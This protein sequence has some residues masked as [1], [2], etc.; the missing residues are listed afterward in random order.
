MLCG[1]GKESM[2]VCV[3]SGIVCGHASPTRR[4]MGVVDASSVL[5]RHDMGLNIYTGHRV[6]PERVQGMASQEAL[7]IQGRTLPGT[8][9]EYASLRPTHPTGHVNMQSTTISGRAQSRSSA[10]RR[11]LSGA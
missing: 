5:N 7:S 11:G 2:A 1:D 9:A 6:L 3:E 10:T 8:L 4:G